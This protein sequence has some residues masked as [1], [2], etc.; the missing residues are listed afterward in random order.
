M[1]GIQLVDDVLHERCDH[2]RGSC[3]HDGIFAFRVQQHL[4]QA[5]LHGVC[6][7]ELCS[8]CGD[9]LF[10]SARRSLMIW[11]KHVI[12][13]IRVACQAFGGVLSTVGRRFFAIQNLRSFSPSEFQRKHSA[14]MSRGHYC[15]SSQ[16][17]ATARISP[18]NSRFSTRDVRLERRGLGEEFLTG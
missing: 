14:L 16:N 15:T 11:C 13:L 9:R 1:Y 5:L 12:L 18:R 3:V 6:A 8:F 10:K 17:A 2:L 4:I 7:H